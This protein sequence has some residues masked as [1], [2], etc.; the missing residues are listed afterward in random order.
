[1]E[2]VRCPTHDKDFQIPTSERE[3]FLG[4]Y[5]QDVENCRLHHEKFPDCRFEEVHDS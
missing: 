5:H 3:F 2:L 4:K 1:M